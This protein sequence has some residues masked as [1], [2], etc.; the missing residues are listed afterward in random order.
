[1]D[2]RRE[3]LINQL[4]IKLKSIPTFESIADFILERDKKNADPIIKF[5]GTNDYIDETLKNMGCE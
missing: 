5:K 2:K 4:T 3:E 1:M